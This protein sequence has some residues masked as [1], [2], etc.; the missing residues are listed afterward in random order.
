MSM[1]FKAAVLACA[2]LSLTGCA[3]KPYEPIVDGPKSLAFN[4]DLSQC[5]AISEQKQTD[6][7]GAAIGAVYYGALAGLFGGSTGDVVASIAVGAAA[8][9][10]V[11]SSEVR[12]QQDAIV[13]RCMRGRGHN[14]IG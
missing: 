11:E 6:G 10:A 9:A 5:R 8:G 14:V 12:S 13:F 7:S 1:P 3:P 2:G 4:S